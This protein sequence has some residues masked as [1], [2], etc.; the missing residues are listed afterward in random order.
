MRRWLSHIFGRTT[1]API[2]RPRPA[3]GRL[4]VEGLEDRLTPTIYVSNGNL[5]VTCGSGNDQVSVNY[6]STPGFEAYRV[7]ENSDVRT[8]PAGL[9]YGGQVVFNGNGG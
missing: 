1:T 8:I 2:R 6:V 9:V 7:R 4:R 3:A 5:Y